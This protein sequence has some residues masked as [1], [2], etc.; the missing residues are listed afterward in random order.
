MPSLHEAYRCL[1]MLDGKP[2]NVKWPKFSPLLDLDILKT[3]K[4]RYSFTFLGFW[5]FE[6]DKPLRLCA[7]VRPEI[8]LI[9]YLSDDKLIQERSRLFQN[10]ETLN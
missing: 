10:K 8:N 9:I 3:A 1:Q 7:C 2:K 6:I 5:R 4:A